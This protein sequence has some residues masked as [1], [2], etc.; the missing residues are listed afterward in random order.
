MK[1]F[2]D[3]VQKISDEKCK[4]RNEITM[5]YLILYNDHTGRSLIRNCFINLYQYMKL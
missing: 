3:K 5:P 4:T 2:S 1:Y